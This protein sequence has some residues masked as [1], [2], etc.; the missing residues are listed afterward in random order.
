MDTIHFQ[1]ANIGCT[2]C[3]AKACYNKIIPRIIIL[4]CLKVGL[5]Y[6][7]G[8]F[9]ATIFYNMQYYITTAFGTAMQIN[10]FEKLVALYIIGQ[11]STDRPS[12]WTML[13][14]VLL[15]CYH[16][17]CK[18]FTMADPANNIKLKYNAGMFVDDS[19]LMH[20]DP[21]HDA[22][23]HTL[24]TNIQHNT[25]TWGRLLWAS[26]GLFEFLKST[27]FLLIWSFAASGQSM[28]ISEEDLPTNVVWL[29]NVNGNSA[30]LY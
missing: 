2:D 23:P 10:F 28:I 14:D 12:G 15:K 29:T 6:P 27:Y 7:T 24:M 25:E 5:A 17:L 9:F 8:V 22:T 4:T 21:Q 3:D 19:T 11:G 26:G 1:H 18:G 20:N 30:V 16:K 13:S